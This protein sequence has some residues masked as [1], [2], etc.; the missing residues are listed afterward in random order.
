MDSIM[1]KK[2]A[3]TV[4]VF[5]SSGC[6]GT[7]F[8]QPVPQLKAFYYLIELKHTIGSIEALKDTVS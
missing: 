6:T 7:K 4:E 2:S 3:F 1:A 8:I 5:D